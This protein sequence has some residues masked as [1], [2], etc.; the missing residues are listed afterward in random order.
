MSQDVA[1][2]LEKG[3]LTNP[4]WSVVEGGDKWGFFFWLFEFLTGCIVEFAR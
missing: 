1:G 3:R 4:P 2:E